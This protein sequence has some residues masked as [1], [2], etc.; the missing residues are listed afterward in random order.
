MDSVDVKQLGSAESSLERISE[1]DDREILDRQHAVRVWL[2]RILSGAAAAGVISGCEDMDIS[3]RHED[4][5]DA[6]TQ[7]ES[8]YNSQES[9]NDSFIPEFGDPRKMTIVADAGSIKLYGNEP[10]PFDTKVTIRVVGFNGIQEQ[11]V[12]EFEAGE[13]IEIE[14]DFQTAGEGNVVEVRDPA[15]RGID[16]PL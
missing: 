5:V 6:S 16:I 12:F 7:F 11:V 8:A 2:R 10:V 4:N 14:H 13:F 9:V 1:V 15:G 3:D